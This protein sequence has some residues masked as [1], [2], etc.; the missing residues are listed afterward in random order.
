MQI[1]AGCLQFWDHLYRKDIKL[2]QSV[3]G[4][5]DKVE[6]RLKAK[7]YDKSL[8]PSNLLL[9]LQNIFNAQFSKCEID[10]KQ[11]ISMRPQ[12]MFYFEQNTDLG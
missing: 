4:R 1:Y 3:R 8:K 7:T 10:I 9:F 12:K 2:L 6:K 5:T 11:F